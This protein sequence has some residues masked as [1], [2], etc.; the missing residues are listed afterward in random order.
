MA[1]VDFPAF[2]YRPAVALHPVRPSQV[3]RPRRSAST[4]LYAASGSL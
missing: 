3:C 4:C 1:Q 2:R